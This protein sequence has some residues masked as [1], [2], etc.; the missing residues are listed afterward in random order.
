M[1]STISHLVEQFLAHARIYYR[2]SNE[3]SMLMYALRPLDELYGELPVNEFGPKQLKRYRETLMERGH[4]RS[5][6]N[7]STSRVRRAIAWGVEEELCKAKVLKR[8]ECV[9]PLKRNRTTAVESDPIEPAYHHDVQR[10]LEHVPEVVGAM[11]ETQRLTGMRPGEVVSMRRCDIDIGHEIWCYRPAHHKNQWRGQRREVYIGPQGQELLEPWFPPAYRD[12]LFSPRRYFKQPRYS[13]CYTVHA[14]R[15][16]IKKWCRRLSIPVWTPNQLRHEF[17]TKV[18]ETGGIEDAQ[19]ALGHAR[20]E[21]TEIYAKANRE[22][23]REL[24]KAIG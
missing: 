15:N 22:R 11:I 18:R 13:P 4:T 16:C 24:M 2:E 9:A 21:T 3:A 17:A 7:K 6:I 14:Y 1:S 19:A 10:V 23:A 8:L 5:G 12:Y 20:I